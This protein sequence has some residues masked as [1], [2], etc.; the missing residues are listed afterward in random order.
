MTHFI[1][2]FLLYKYCVDEHLPYDKQDIDEIEDEHEPDM[3]D[4][5]ED[6]QQEL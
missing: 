2:D 4:E 5:K 1:S 6:L 3:G